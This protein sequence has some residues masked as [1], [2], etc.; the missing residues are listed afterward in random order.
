MKQIAKLNYLWQE[1]SLIDA[2]SS[3]SELWTLNIQEYNAQL[4]AIIGDT[5]ISLVFALYLKH[6]IVAPRNF[7]AGTKIL[8]QIVIL[9]EKS[10]KL[11]F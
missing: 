8:I 5:L 11:L 4:D 3:S 2:L 7:F 10:I 9:H 1:D 6:E